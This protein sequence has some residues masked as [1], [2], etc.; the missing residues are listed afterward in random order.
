MF[1]KA[2]P[3]P[4][5]LIDIEFEFGFFGEAQANLSIDQVWAQ[6]YKHVFHW[7]WSNQGNESLQKV[8]DIINTSNTHTGKIALNGGIGVGAYGKIGIAFI[9]TSSLD[10]AEIGLKY[11]GGVSLEGTYVPYM[12]DVEYAKKSTDLY[13]QI[14]DR[15]IAVYGF[16]GLT[17]DANLFKWSV[18]KEIPNFLDIPINN[19][20]LWGGFRSVPL[21]ANTK[22]K[23]DATGVY[24]AQTSIS[25]EV[26]HTDIGFALIN[27]DNEEDA[28]FSY[29][30]YDYTG[31]KAEA[32]ASF[33]GKPSSANYRV[34]PLVKYMGMELICEPSAVIDKGT[35]TFK[36]AEIINV[37]SEP[38]YNGDGEYLFTWYTTNFSYII[39]IKGAEFIEYIQP[40][41]FENN[42]WSYNDN[43][44]KVP[45]N[46][47][48]SVKSKMSYDSDAN[49]NMTTGYE[50]TMKDGSKIYSTNNLRFGGS[51]DSPTIS[52]TED[53]SINL[54]NCQAPL[55][56]RTN[57]QSEDET[58]CI[59]Q[60]EFE[61][62]PY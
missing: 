10:I 35:I 37:N 12:R 27:E 40:V 47:L 16:R 51:P 9:T 39:Q 17:F 33:Y 58:F 60:L 53:E 24:D 2:I 15:E 55:M 46:G 48:Y 14:K 26:Q 29:G 38:K 22:L 5:A 4:E 21:F 42:A 7:E 1:R 25:G 49:M 54:L 18:S 20:E 52:V 28:T 31:P 59:E 3:I 30:T 50:I 61:P 13:N 19:R 41:I 57:E 56:I 34:Y 62:I 23:F 36:S 43:K 8:N 32:Y 45:G 44:T 11:R 6:N